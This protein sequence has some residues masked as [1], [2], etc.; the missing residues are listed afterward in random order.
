MDD[1]DIDEDSYM[2][3]ESSSSSHRHLKRPK[4]NE[5]VE[6]DDD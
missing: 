6:L 4:P 5:V 2:S 1:E 3:E